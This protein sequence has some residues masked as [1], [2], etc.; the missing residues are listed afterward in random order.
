MCR[1][2]D[3]GGKVAVFV[4]LEAGD[5]AEAVAQRIGQHTGAGGR[6]DKR[7]GRQVDFDGTGGGPFAYHNVEPVVFERG[8]EDFFHNRA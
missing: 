3:D 7:E 6:A 8:V 4:K 5:D 2:A 1:T